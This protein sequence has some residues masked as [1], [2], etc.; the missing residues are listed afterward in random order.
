MAKKA[1]LTLGVKI[2]SLDKIRELQKDNPR[3]CIVIDGPTL[4]FTESDTTSELANT[5]F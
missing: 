2:K 5:F 1:N 4:A 3:M